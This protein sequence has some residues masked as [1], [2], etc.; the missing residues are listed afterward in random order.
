MNG[1]IKDA[2]DSSVSFKKTCSIKSIKII[3]MRTLNDNQLTSTLK[4][5]KSNKWNSK[6]RFR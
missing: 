6:R 2:T 1:I 4:K 3:I 5:S